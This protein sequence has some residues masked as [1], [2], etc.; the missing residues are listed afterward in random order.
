MKI[1]ATHFKSLAV[2]AL[3]LTSF[4]T[5]AGIINSRTDLNT[6]LGGNQVLEDFETPRLSGQVRYLGGPL[7][8]DTTFSATLGNHLVQPGVTFQRNP[9]YTL[10]SGYRGIDWNPAGYFGAASQA[11]SGAG[12]SGGAS[13]RNDFQIVFT[14]PVTAFGVDL[15]AY[16]GYAA[17]GIVSVYDTA[18][19]LLSSTNISG[20]AGTGTF[21]GWENADGIGKIT[22][23]DTPDRNYIQFDNLGFGVTPVPVP[24]AI[25]LFASAL[26]G[27][28]VLGRR[29]QAATA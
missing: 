10:A 12:G 22:V 14:A 18:G 27:L 1:N 25:W 16:S 19:T 15:M 11:L 26:T 5:H 9:D 8:D 7:N 6:L 4:N 28:G 13:I 29:K 20:T 23:H 24:A 21:F 3:L 17:D 2:S